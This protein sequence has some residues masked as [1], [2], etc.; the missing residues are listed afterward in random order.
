[1]FLALMFL[2]NIFS[3]V[4]PAFAET[5][6]WTGAYS[7]L[8]AEYKNGYVSTVRNI[9]AA[10][11]NGDAAVQGVDY[12]AS[13]DTPWGNSGDF[14]MVAGDWCYINVDMPY[15]GV[16]A[17]QLY[18]LWASNFPVVYQVTTDEG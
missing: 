4:V 3:A 5:L 6:T 18:T 12:Q 8:G 15:T 11:R 14:T 9:Q 2:V 17:M 10:I 7:S 1:M 16:Y 13:F